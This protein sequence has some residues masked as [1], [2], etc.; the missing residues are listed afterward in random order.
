M[1]ESPLRQH[2]HTLPRSTLYSNTKTTVYPLCRVKLAPLPEKLCIQA[3]QWF[4]AVAV[5]RRVDRGAKTWDALTT[6]LRG[7]MDEIIRM[8]RMAADQG[9]C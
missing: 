7:E 2:S 6:S 8:L 3:V 9:P 5:K 4:G 1:M